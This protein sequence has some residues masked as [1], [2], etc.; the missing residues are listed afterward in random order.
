MN[1]VISAL[2]IILLLTALSSRAEYLAEANWLK[3]PAGRETLG[4][5]HGDVAV[6]AAGEIY[7]SLQ[8]PQAGLQVFDDQGRFLRNIL[9]APSDLHGFIIHQEEDGEYIYGVR[10]YGQTILKMDLNG[11]LIMTIG[12]ASI[13]DRYKIL[14][15]R[16][17][18]PMVMLTSVAVA[19]NGDLYVSDGYA[20][21]YIHRFDK[22]GRY[23]ES[24]G[25]KEAPYHF[26]MLH[27][28][29]LDDR[30]QPPRLIASDRV[31]NRVV[32]LSL[33]GEFLGVLA[34]DLLLPDAVAIYGDLAL[35]AEFN[36]RLSVLDKQG[37]IR[38]RVGEN[39]EEGI[40]SNDFPP[41]KWR[42]GF[43]VTPHGVATNAGGDIFISEFSIYGRVHRFKRLDRSP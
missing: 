27:K 7:L 13:P 42:P 38:E 36:G 21:D 23:L 26:N 11:N 29:A 30:F 43:L 32:H 4:D 6:S 39:T 35:V 28:L 10:V 34:E 18:K 2:T 15:P 22:S 12:S 37:K 31:N 41:G 20:S 9:G 5:Q 8:D 25:G 40:G 33:R 1:K 17:G 24:F 3:L 14:N 19:P 16:T